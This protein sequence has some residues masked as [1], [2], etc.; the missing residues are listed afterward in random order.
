MGMKRGLK[1]LISRSWAWILGWLL[2]VR[3]A[4]ALKLAEVQT[5]KSWAKAVKWDSLARVS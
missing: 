2:G 5:S 4:R 1:V 3:A